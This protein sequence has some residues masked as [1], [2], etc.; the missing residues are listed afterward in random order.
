M[1]NSHPGAVNSPEGNLATRAPSPPLDPMTIFAFLESF[2]CAVILVA[3]IWTNRS[4]SVGH[5][6]LNEAAM[7]ALVSYAPI[8]NLVF[9][10]LP[11]KA[12]ARRGLVAG[13]HSDSR[14]RGHHGRRHWL[15]GKRLAL[16][17]L[18]RRAGIVRAV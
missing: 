5:W 10:A 17:A 16:A 11:G 4:N 15:L 7:W 18:L 3:L 8:S 14:D 13:T 6:R 12:T 9:F 1:E 2:L